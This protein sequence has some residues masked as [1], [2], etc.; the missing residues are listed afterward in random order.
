MTRPLTT[1]IA[2]A[3]FLP[4][5]CTRS[6]REA[7]SEKPAVAVEVT[8]IAPAD[9]KESIAVVGTLEPKFHA[10]VKAEYS[11]VITNVYV[12]EW[13]RVSK[14]TLLARF[15]VR[16]AEA[17]LRA[18]QA[19]RLQAEVGATRAKRELE[20]LI[21]LKESGLATQQNLDDART[22]AE[23]AEAQ[24]AA[25]AAE[26]ALARTRLSKAE[27]RAPMSGVISSRSV[28]PGDFVENMGSPKP[29]FRIVDNE[30]LDLTVSIP[31]SQISRVRLG[32]PLWF[33]TDAVPDRTF[34][35]RV[36][37]INPAADEGSRAVKVIAAVDNS[38][39]A[40]RAGLF[41]Q[42]GIVVGERRDVL[43]IP[44]TALLTWDPV[45][46]AAVV[47]VVAGDR[48]QRRDIATGSAFGELV[49]VGRGI[50]AGEAV[51]TRGAFNLR[52][53]DRVTVV[54]APRA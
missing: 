22:A 53:G 46:H 28:N 45:G 1:L 16:E 50:S 2:F 32:Q 23:A 52:D 8:R 39:G 4:G 10:L 36:S 19:G 51:V 29:M 20:R 26:E 37:F 33:T 31:S 47:F 3:L 38:G 15:D 44:R 9:V 17:A 14:G 35:G 18:V 42:G 48:A 7:V 12:T 54:G 21:K 49:E 13:V 41:A 43:S 40:L 34:E 5:G 6:A 25:A 30:R 11:G 27:V 24:L